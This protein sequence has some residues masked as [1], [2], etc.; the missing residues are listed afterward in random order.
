MD[1]F[2]RQLP[3]DNMQLCSQWPEIY[4]RLF[5]LANQIPESDSSSFKI[6]CLSALV[7]YVID[8][9]EEYVENKAILI[10]KVLENLFE[11]PLPSLEEI[12]RL[13]CHLLDVSNKNR[14]INLALI[15]RIHYHYRL[16]ERLREN[17]SVDLIETILLSLQ[18]FDFADEDFDSKMQEQWDTLLSRGVFS[19]ISCDNNK[20]TELELMSSMRSAYQDFY[21]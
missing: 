7:D 16:C 10:Q 20:L 15:Q 21:R 17:K 3:H 11:S 18:K 2:I 9:Q 6:K 12:T 1:E 13:F 5:K 14:M 19:V 8:D 4:D